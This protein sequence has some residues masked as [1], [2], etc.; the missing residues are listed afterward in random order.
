MTEQSGIRAHRI[1]PPENG[2][3]GGIPTTCQSSTT[4]TPPCEELHGVTYIFCM[5]GDRPIHILPAEYAR[6]SVLGLESGAERR[7]AS[8]GAVRAAALATGLPHLSALRAHP[9]GG[10]PVVVS[11]AEFGAQPGGCAQGPAQGVLGAAGA[12]RCP[13][14]GAEPPGEALLLGGCQHLALSFTADLADDVGVCVH[15]AVLSARAWP[16][17][18]GRLLD[19]L[20]GPAAGGQR[21]DYPFLAG[22]TGGVQ[23]P[24]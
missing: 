10:W 2:S 20:A 17:C 23:L 21:P 6:L 19:R 22:V 7:S 1:G 8:S 14:L 13:G 3:S 9:A 11:C 12:P 5:T 16:G 18:S 24:T 4:S 15:V